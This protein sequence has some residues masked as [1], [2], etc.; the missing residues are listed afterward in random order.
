[1]ALGGVVALAAAW[2]LTVALLV[3]DLIGRMRRGTYFRWQGVGTLL[4]IGAML[5]SAFAELR[6]WPAGQLYRLRMIADPVIVAG[7]ALVIVA[8]S[9]PFRARRSNKPAE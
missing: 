9:V 3:L 5:T 8:A 4:A 7:A 6:G 2:L 1:M